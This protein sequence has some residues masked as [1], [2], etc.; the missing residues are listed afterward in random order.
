[1][2]TQKRLYLYC[3]LQHTYSCSEDVSCGKPH[4][5][6]MLADV[7]QHRSNS[8]CNGSAVKVPASSL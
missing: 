5:A 4:T 6:D 7:V 8:H 1:M 3:R 2:S